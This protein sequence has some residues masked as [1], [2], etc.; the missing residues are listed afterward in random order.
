MWP[1]NTGLTVYVVWFTKFSRI[2][3]LSMIMNGIIF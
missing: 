2:F 3:E 1:L